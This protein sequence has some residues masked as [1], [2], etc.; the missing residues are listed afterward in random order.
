[1]LPEDTKYFT[2]V[3][4]AHTIR[5]KNCEA[6]EPTLLGFVEDGK[7]NGTVFPSRRISESC[8][9]NSNFGDS[10]AFSDLDEDEP[11]ADYGAEARD[12]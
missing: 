7:E 4:S 9:G 11:C 8:M 12:I 6:A 5:D 2:E 3:S 10:R 1:M